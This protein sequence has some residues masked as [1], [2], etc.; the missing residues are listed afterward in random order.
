ML[1]G[2]GHD[3]AD[4]LPRLS[5]LVLGLADIGA[6]DDADADDDSADDG[7]A[8]DVGTVP[9]GVGELLLES[10]IV[11]LP[12][13]LGIRPAAGSAVRLHASTPTQRI[14]TTILPVWHRLRLRLEASDEETG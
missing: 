10:L 4:E 7:T 11:D 12:V 13:E 14:E 8:A 6:D 5:E 2:P 9:D 3:T 1:R